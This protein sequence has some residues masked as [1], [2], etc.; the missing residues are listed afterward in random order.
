MNAALKKQIIHKKVIYQTGV[1]TGRET[2]RL[3]SA[4]HTFE[5]QHLTYFTE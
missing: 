2:W 3:F 1:N 4:Q 5:N